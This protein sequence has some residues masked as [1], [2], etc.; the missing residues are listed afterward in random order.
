[1]KFFDPKRHLPVGWDWEN[2]RWGLGWGHTAS[3]TSIGF[4]L[5]RYIDARASLFRYIQQPNGTLVKELVAGRIIAPFRELM[6][7]MPYLGMWCFLLTMVWQA[8]RHYQYHTRDSM[9]IY[10]MRRLPDQWEL[11]RRCLT[12][13]VLSAI[14]NM[15]LFAAATALCWVLYCTATPAGHLPA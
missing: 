8:L 13:P 3:L 2:L 7:G 9:P 6:A 14:A 1:M 15:L 10:L 11:H 4:F 12:V 5:N